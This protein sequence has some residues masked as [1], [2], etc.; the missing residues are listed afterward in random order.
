MGQVEIIIPL[1]LWLSEQLGVG[2]DASTWSIEKGLGFELRKD[3][4]TFGL[5]L[6]DKESV[7]SP[8]KIECYARVVHD[9]KPIGK[10]EPAV[11]TVVVHLGSG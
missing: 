4:Q 8:E 7:L 5:G 10:T 1:R 11:A 2:A 6:G 3:D 9:I